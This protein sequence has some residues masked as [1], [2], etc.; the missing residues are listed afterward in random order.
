MRNILAILAV[1]AASSMPAGAQLLQLATDEVNAPIYLTHAGDAR[2]FVLTRGGTIRILSGGALLPTPF[3]DL[4]AK[5]DDRGEGGLLGLAFDPDY[6]TNGAFY[7]SYTT[8]DPVDGFS[9]RLSRFHV[10]DGDPN[11][12]DPA[13]D[14]MLQVEQPFENHNGGA[15]QFGPDGML[16][17]GFGDGGYRDD[18]GCRAQREETLLG[19]MLRIDPVATGGAAPFYTIPPDNPFAAPGDGVLDEILDFGLRNPWRFSFDRDSG[20]LWIGDVGQDAVEEVDLRPAW[21][22][23]PPGTLNWGWKVVEGNSCTGL[24]LATCGGPVPACG[25]PAYT[26]PVDTYPHTGDNRSITGGYVYRGALA[27]GFA[28]VYVFGDFASGRIF[29]LREI[30]P[31]SWQRSTLLEPGSGQWASFGEGPDGELYAIDLFADAIYRIDL[32]AAI[33]N[34]DRAC[35]LGLND[36]FAKLAKARAG[37]LAR[38]I[39]KGAGG[40]LPGTVEA[41]AAAADPKL[42]KAAAKATAFGAARCAVVPP[43]GPSSAATVAG[44]AVGGETDWV[45]A[46]FGADLDAALASRASDPAGASCQAQVRAAVARCSARRV[47]EF[48]RCKAA[49]LKDASVKSAATLAACLDADPQGKVHAACDAATGDLAARVLPKSCV[50]KAVNLATAF[51]GCAAADAVAVAT[52]ADR[53]GRCAACTALSAADALGADCDLYD[54]GVAD[55]SC[56]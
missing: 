56:P 54:D 19:K 36:H 46:L 47:K 27:P 13:E 7:V 55:A 1:A 15:V 51:P 29:A 38:C 9:S 31:G 30:A 33:S 43:F 28:G 53:A 32:T 37:Q 14:V 17:F 2:L 10:S 21:G 39:A 35:I 34:A 26:G 16:Y 52:C 20:D 41:C 44:A 50:A 48:D 6:A 3:L 8:N 23:D 42:E 45:R 25:S 5:V 11:V 22:A 49:G 18:P 40:K 12:A 24:D 4:G